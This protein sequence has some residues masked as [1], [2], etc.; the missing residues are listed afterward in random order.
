MSTNY[1]R[2]IEEEK[3]TSFERFILTCAKAFGACIDMRDEPLDKKIPIFTPDNYYTEK[4][5]RNIKRLKE[6]NSFTET[7]F[8]RM[9]VEKFN[10]RMK[11][12]KEYIKEALELKNKYDNM[13]KKVEEWTPPTEDHVDLK[14]FMIEQIK[15]SV[16]AIYESSHYPVLLTVNEFKSNEL[17][18]IS[19][20]IKYCI[21]ENEKEIKRAN[22]RNLWIKQL[23][24]SLLPTE[25]IV[26]LDRSDLIKGKHDTPVEKIDISHFKNKSVNLHDIMRAD[27]IFFIDGN[28]T[29][30]LK[31]RF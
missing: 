23:R 12:H 13:L 3:E 18:K 19:R 6:F 29:K 4:L 17:T 22:E 11:I 9:T 28:I 20:N 10:N 14:Q 16:S 27:K 30:T 25:N 21:E 2:M 26:K 8:K 31:D 5:V 7:D 15:M 1:T 24:E